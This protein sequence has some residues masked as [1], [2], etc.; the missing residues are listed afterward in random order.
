MLKVLRNPTSIYRNF[1]KAASQANY[2]MAGMSLVAQPA[3]LQKKIHFKGNPRWLHQDVKVGSKTVSPEIDGIHI[4]ELAKQCYSNSYDQFASR[5]IDHFCNECITRLGIDIFKQFV[6]FNQHRAPYLKESK[7]FEK[8]L[9]TCLR[10][11]NQDAFLLRLL[12][13]C[14]IKAINK[15][16]VLSN[17]IS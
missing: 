10:I 5:K 11:L 6:E 15:N 13:M 9:P 16:S 7:D 17:L 12:A 3:K 4:L 1:S 14:N 2:E 8:H